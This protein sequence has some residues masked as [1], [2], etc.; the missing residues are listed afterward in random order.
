MLLA[1]RSRML[2]KYCL[3]V[4]T[5]ENCNRY[6]EKLC[7][8]ASIY[9]VGRLKCVSILNKQ[10]REHGIMSYMECPKTFVSSLEK[11]ILPE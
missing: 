5:Y 3:C 11:Q 9:L 4:L 10:S 8:E 2:S 7:I 1:V 6:F